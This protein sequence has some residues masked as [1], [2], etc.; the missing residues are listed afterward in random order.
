MEEGEEKSSSSIYSLLPHHPPSLTHCG[1]LGEDAGSSV[2][3]E[4]IC[5]CGY[6]SAVGET[7]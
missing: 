5:M 7:G 1:M 2:T 4:K 6:R 3:C